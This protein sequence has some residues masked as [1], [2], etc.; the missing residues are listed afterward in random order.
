MLLAAVF[1]FLGREPLGATALG[2]ISFSWLGTALVDYAAAPDPTVSALG[3]MDL[4]LALWPGS[5]RT[6]AWP[7]RAR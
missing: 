1:A 6:P 4:A 2:L 3:V 5:A 7:G